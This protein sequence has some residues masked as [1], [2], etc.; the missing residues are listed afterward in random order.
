MPVSDPP[1]AASDLESTNPT[2]DGMTPET[3]PCGNVFR[4]AYKP[5]SPQQKRDI[6]RIKDQAAFLYGDIDELGGSRELSLAKTKLEEC[7]FWA[8]KHLTA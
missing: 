2:P 4:H 7:V 1:L 3:A 5:V 6:Q 8:T